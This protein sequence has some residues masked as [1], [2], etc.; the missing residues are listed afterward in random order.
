[1]SEQTTKRPLIPLLAHTFGTRMLIGCISVVIGLPLGLA[2]IVGAV[3]VGTSAAESQSSDLILLGVTL[4]ICAASVALPVGFVGLIAFRRAR[5]FDPLVTPLGLDGSIYA[6]MWRQYTGMFEG[7]EAR[8]RVIRGPR[9]ELRLAGDVN[10]RMAVGTRTAFGKTI[11]SVANIRTVE[12]TDPDFA[13]LAASGRDPDWTRAL[14][15]DPDTR[16]AVLRLTRDVAATE[17]RTLVV[18]PGALRLSINYV[19]LSILTTDNLRVWLTDMATVAGVA[20]RLPAP[21]S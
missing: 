3:L 10:T 8:V 9:I 17:M 6:I 4:M 18:E 14:L 13:H 7:R 12:L 5:Q 15:T 11:A 19:P 21:A 20:E 1:M 2:C 16:E